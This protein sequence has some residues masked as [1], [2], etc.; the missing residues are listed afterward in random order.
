MGAVCSLFFVL[1][2]PGLRAEAP[3]GTANSP[4]AQAP[5]SPTSEPATAPA[6]KSAEPAASPVAKTYVGREKCEECHEDFKDTFHRTLHAKNPGTSPTAANQCEACH[7][8]GS[9][10][11]DDNEPTSIVSPKRLKPAQVNAICQKCH[12]SMPGQYDWRFSAHAMSNVAC[13]ECHSVHPKKKDDLQPKLLR[14][15]D[16]KDI[17]YT[18]HAEVRGQTYMP[19]HHPIEEG[20]I[21]CTDCHNVHGAGLS[22]YKNAPNTRELCLQCHQQYRGPFAV[23]H[24]PVSDDCVNCHRPH[25]SMETTLLQVS[26]PFLCQR[27][28]STVHNPHVSPIQQTGSQIATQALF[29]SRCT[30]CHSNVHGSE[31]SPTFTR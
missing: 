1:L 10:H 6:T 23:E 4:V 21:V 20:R 18:C 24:Q 8:P 28:H 31:Q 15:G 9:V 27:C 2:S 12:E 26:E 14:K 17:C 7:G 30:T 19:S 16:Q 11:V 29:F 3:H 13:T 22:K 5:A 25:G